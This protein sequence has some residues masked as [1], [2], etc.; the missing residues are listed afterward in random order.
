MESTPIPTLL[1]ITPTPSIPRSIVE[2]IAGAA[3]LT[4]LIE[5]G[6]KP[7]D[8]FM[9]VIYTITA[10]VI[11]EEGRSKERR[12]YLFKCYPRHPARQAYLNKTNMFHNE[13]SFYSIWVKALK[14]FQTDV[15]EIPLE[16]VLTPAFPPYIGGKA[17]DFSKRSLEEDSSKIYQPIE[18]F[19]VLTDLRRELGY[20]M[21]D[22]T[23]GL[24]LD[25]INLT[26]IELAKIHALSWAYRQKVE[27][28]L[29]KKFPFLEPAFDD[30]DKVM[31][32]NIVGQNV[33]IAVNTMDEALG[34]GNHLTKSILTIGGKVLKVIELFL[35]QK[36]EDERKGWELHREPPP[37]MV[38]ASEGESKF[39]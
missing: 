1:P 20:K 33:E 24:E 29:L 9:S 26:I 13:L 37:E 39:K 22:R 7:G 36:E 18:N 14:E 34:P 17:I 5:D 8:N 25:H 15:L 23:V 16:S 32:G 27:D 6:S 10:D 12:H 28:N 30:E 3:V 4:Y 38:K 35:D 2:E 19:I 21:L 31:W 11:T